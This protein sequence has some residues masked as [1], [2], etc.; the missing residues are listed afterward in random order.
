MILDG[1]PTKCGIES[2]VIGFTDGPVLLRPGAIPREDI[3]AF[4]GALRAPGGS[5]WGSPDGS[6]STTR[7]RTR[8]G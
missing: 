8:C 2:T 7:R 3:E 5:T 1:G 4:V 6:K